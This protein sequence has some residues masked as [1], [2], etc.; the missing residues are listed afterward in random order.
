MCIDTELVLP[1]YN[2]H[3]Y[4]SLKNLGK[5]CTLYM[6]K[7]G[8]QLFK[9]PICKYSPILGNEGL[10]LQHVKFEG[11]QFSP[12]RCLYKVQGPES[13]GVI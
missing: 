6:A 9:G 12:Y 3:P 5:K 11:T 2:E 10:G 8:H 7:Y 1:M 13:T 4:F